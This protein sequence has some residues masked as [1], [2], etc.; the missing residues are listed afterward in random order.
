MPQPSRVLP[1]LV[2]ALATLGAV[3]V[4]LGVVYNL[5]G[6][7]ALERPFGAYYRLDLDVYRLGGTVFAHGDPI[8]GQLPLTAFGTP[9]PF[10]YPPLAAISFAPM[11]WMSLTAASTIMT[12]VSIVALA[13]SILLTMRSLGITDTALWLSGGAAAL[14]LAF[15]A[16]PVF[17]TLN[18]GQVNLLLMALVLADLLPRK[19]PWPRGLL[20]GF[21]AAFKLTP[22]IFVLYL[23]LR[24][25][26]RA[27]LVT[28][29][30]FVAFTLLGFVLAFGD[31]AKYWTQ[32]LP[33]SNRI[34]RPAYPA[35]QSLTGVLARLGVEDL[36]TPLWL[37]GSLV[38]LALAVV[39]MRRAL[40]ADQTALAVCV[41]ALAGLLISPVSW[42]HHWVWAVP[43]LLTLGVLAWRRR[44]LSLGLWV[45]LGA[46]MFGF[47]PHWILA[48][49]RTSGLGWPLPDQLLA[50]SYV[51][52]GLATLVILATVRR[53]APARTEA[54]LARA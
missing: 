33:D 40:A 27:V 14:G 16:E 45:L 32:I 41:N 6:L 34:G 26:V 38:V 15:V 36:R 29:I 19:T 35:N 51:W 17:S 28:G 24:R 13:A 9:L 11:S 47:A 31:S 44:S 37:L 5:I 39:A 43:I 52:W 10:T 12:I 46:A 42:S 21:V 2:A 48:P 4:T 54:A 53:S 18:Y 7:P 22:A 8:Y 20:I 25:D 49:G 3:G 1:V 50:S 23:L 30:S